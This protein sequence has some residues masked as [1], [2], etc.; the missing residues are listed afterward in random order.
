MGR[1][2]AAVMLAGSTGRCDVNRQVR[3][4]ISVLAGLAAVVLAFA[5]ASSIRSDAEAAQEEAL[6]RYGGELVAVCVAARN[7]APGDTLDETNVTVEQW[8]ASLL[9]EDAFTS[10]EDV[11]GKTAT[12]AIPQRAVLCPAYT[13]TRSDGLDVPDGTVA[14]CLASDPAHAA[15]G[16]LERGDTVDV[17]VS[18]DS[19]ADRLCEA[20]V[21]D[22]S[23]LAAGGGEVSWVTVAVDP[24]SV[25][26]LL[27]ATTV[28]QVTLVVPGE[29]VA[30][31]T[32]EPADSAEQAKTP[33]TEDTEDTAKTGDGA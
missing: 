30:T 16:A 18:G 15:G 26:E 11:A 9:P 22:T 2:R 14:V 17:Y 19:I 24:A 7:I 4:A 13:E 1:S 28:G 3:L 27:A 32:E 29:R 21:L 33:D 10:L 6:A 12:S 25:P 8:V 20:R 31:A 5:Y 23:A